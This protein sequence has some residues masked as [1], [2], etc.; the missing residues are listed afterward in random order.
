MQ[1]GPGPP[2]CHTAAVPEVLE[3]E[4]TRQAIAPLVGRRI[5]AIERTDDLAVGPGVDAV[6]AGATV[7]AVSRRGKLLVLATDHGDIGVHLGM[8]GRLLLGDID[9]L[10]LLAYGASRDDPVWDRW[11]ARLDDG[12]SLRLNDP[13]RL[14]RIWL[15]PEPDRLGPDALTLTRRELASALAG[16]TAPLKAV[17]LDQRR[18]AGLGN[19]LV[20]EVLWRAGL[21]PHRPGG[22]LDPDE[23]AKLQRT[24]RRRL[25]VMM[26]RGG[27]HTGTL[28][29]ALRA[30]LGPCP[31][32]GGGLAR[33]TIA[34]RTTVWCP[35]HQH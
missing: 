20:D 30:V 11:V 6:A 23:V 33:E 25:P 16:R 34:T 8:T 29:P 7:E 35:A 32:C 17:L 18:V 12:R 15:D 5:E 26:S 4:L 28:S 21:D 2:R 10:G 19:L 27:S 1:C 9:A 22:Q 14:G 24:I 3:L 13:R 31:R